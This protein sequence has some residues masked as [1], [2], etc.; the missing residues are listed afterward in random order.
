M[1]TKHN[2]EVL[3]ELGNSLTIALEPHMD[4]LHDM[5]SWDDE[6]AAEVIAARV[7]KHDKRTQKTKAYARAKHRDNYAN[8]RV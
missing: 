6:W 1:K 4:V 8:K 7:A 5:E 2:Q 3:K